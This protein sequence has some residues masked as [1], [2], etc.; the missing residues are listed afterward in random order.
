MYAKF[1]I[2]ALAVLALAVPTAA[3]GAR[4]MPPKPAQYT[5]PS[6]GGGEVTLYVESRKSVQLAAIAFKCGAVT[7]HTNLQ[8]IPIEK[9]KR[10]YRFSIAAHGSVSYSDGRP[11]NN[12]AVSI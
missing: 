2:L 9:T 12:A 8:A 6:R 10:G 4:W 5:G 7:G 3:G 11:D 1:L